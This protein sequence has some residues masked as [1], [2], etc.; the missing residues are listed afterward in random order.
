VTDN[1]TSMVFFVLDIVIASEQEKRM[2]QVSCWIARD[3]HEYCDEIPVGFRAWD[4]LEMHQATTSHRNDSVCL[5][6]RPEIPIPLRVSSSL[7][8]IPF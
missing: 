2:P 3:K 1:A 8:W 6:D 5:R 7:D 4:V